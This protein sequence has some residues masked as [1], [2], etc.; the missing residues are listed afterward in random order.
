G[1]SDSASI[2]VT[3]AAKVPGAPQL[4]AAP[5]ASKGVSLSWAAPASDGGSSITGYR[6]YRA[7]RPGVEALLV[8]VGNVTSYTDT[9]TRKGVTYYYTLTGANAVGEGPAANEPSATARS[10]RRPSG[11]R[12]IDAHTPRLAAGLCQH[13]LRVGK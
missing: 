12:R 11:A 1:K 8:S 9:S 5:G 6:I 7:R 4:N 13:L 2:T 3:T 10:L